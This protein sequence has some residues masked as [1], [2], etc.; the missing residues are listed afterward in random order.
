[1][2]VVNRLWN[3]TRQQD[4]PV[5][6][7]NE[8]AAFGPRPLSLAAQNVLL[9]CHGSEGAMHAASTVIASLAPGARLHQ[10]VVVPEFWQ[11]MSGDGWRINASTEGLFCDYLEGQIERETLE[12]L[13]NV[14]ASATARG[15]LYSAASCCGD[16]ARSLIA[17]AAV[18]DYDLVVIGAPRP[19]RVGGLRSRMDVE[20]LMRGLS[21]PL[22]VIPNPLASTGGRD[23]R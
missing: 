16:P 7:L 19:K 1:M 9:A 15:I 12:V 11:H 17:A 6:A 5:A 23:D 18:G 14:H 10:C 20:A 4:E 22:L 13:R 8:G 21:I 2:G 3:G